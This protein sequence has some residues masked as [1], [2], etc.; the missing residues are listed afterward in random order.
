MEVDHFEESVDRDAQCGARAPTR[1]GRSV[2]DSSAQFQGFV[3]LGF[4]LPGERCAIVPVRIGMRA[5]EALLQGRVARLHPRGIDPAHGLGLG[6]SL[7]FR[8]FEHHRHTVLPGR[9]GRDRPVGARLVRLRLERFGVDRHAGMFARKAC[10]RFRPDVRKV[11]GAPEHSLL[12]FVPDGEILVPTPARKVF[13]RGEGMEEGRTGMGVELLPGSVPLRKAV[14]RQACGGAGEGDVEKSHRLLDLG[15]LEVGEILGLHFARKEDEPS[16][17]RLVAFVDQGNRRVFDGRSPP[18]ARQIDDRVLKPLARMNRLNHDAVVIRIGSDFIAIGH[19]RLLPFGDQLFKAPH[20]PRE[21][22]GGLLHPE[23]EFDQLPIVGERALAARCGQKTA[24][25]FADAEKFP[26][27]RGEARTPCALGRRLHHAAQENQTFGALFL[28]GVGRESVSHDAG[29]AGGLEKTALGRHRHRFE[30]RAE[31]LGLVGTEDVFVGGETHLYAP[32]QKG[33]VKGHP[34]GAGPHENRDVA[35]A[36][37]TPLD[38]VAVAFREHRG[39]FVGDVVRLPLKEFVL[40]GFFKVPEA[41]DERRFGTKDPV[42]VDADER[43]PVFVRRHGVVTNARTEEGARALEKEIEEVHEHRRRPEVLRELSVPPDF[44]R[45]LP[46]GL[47]VRVSEAVDRLL[48]VA[49]EKDRLPEGGVPEK[50]GEDPVLQGIRILEFVDQDDVVMTAHDGRKRRIGLEPGFGA[51]EHVVKRLIRGLA[52][53]RLVPRG[54][55]GEKAF[56]HF[57][58]GRRVLIVKLLGEALV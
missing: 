35:R 47:E 55:P 7:R 37:G 3:V 9:P 28:V 21:G 4:V 6:K 27:G 49:H 32:R 33:V 16:F 19:G 39:D 57:F 48:R 15:A 14:E 52:L 17:A 24:F 8:R 23:E 13:P 56:E 20:E 43:R 30:D 34:V 22:L 10:G 12:E 2:L 18:T 51:N 5:K 45:R 42:F 29:C 38:E 11:R 25:R 54:R 46:I 40:D 26:E 36:Q 53:Q 44:V 50:R 58:V 41:H 1:H 31:F